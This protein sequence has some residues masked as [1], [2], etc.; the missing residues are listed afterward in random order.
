MGFW[1]SV[2][3]HTGVTQATGGAW[4]TVVS[5]HEPIWNWHQAKPGC[6][7]PWAISQERTYRRRLRHLWK[8]QVRAARSLLDGSSEGM[9]SSYNTTQCLGCWESR[10][11]PLNKKSEG[12]HIDLLLMWVLTF[13]MMATWGFLS[14]FITFFI[15]VTCKLSSGLF[16]YL[17]NKSCVYRLEKRCHIY[18]FWVVIWGY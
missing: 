10:F 8:L 2:W 17:H 6:V 12:L 16:I 9:C 4:C 5:C 3:E 7:F 13:A 15:N 11:I 18:H 14:D 1:S